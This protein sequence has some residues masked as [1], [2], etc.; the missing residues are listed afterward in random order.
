MPNVDLYINLLTGQAVRNP[1]SAAPMVR[2]DFRNPGS[3]TLNLYFLRRQDTTTENFSYTRFAT[4]TPQAKL[5]RNKAPDY[6]TFVVSFLG[7]NS[8]PIDARLPADSIARILGKMPSIG[9]GNVSVQGNIAQGFQIEFKEAQGGVAQPALTVK[10][11]TPT[12]GEAVVEQLQ[13]GAIGFNSVQKI[14]FREAPLFTA[15]GWVEIGVPVTPGWSATLDTTGMNERF[16]DIGDLILEVTL[17]SQGVRSGADGVTFLEG[18]TRA[19]ADGQA[20]GNAAENNVDFYAFQDADGIA[21]LVAKDGDTVFGPRLWTS[22]DIGKSIDDGGGWIR[23]ET[24]I[25]SVI[26]TPYYNAAKLNYPFADG[27]FLANDIATNIAHIDIG[28]SVTRIY[29]SATAVFTVNDVGHGIIGDKIPAGTFIERFIDIQ[30]VVL[31]AAATGVA[32]GLSWT[33]IAIAGNRFDSASALF[34]GADLGAKIEA[35][36]IPAGTYITSIV[37][38]T[39]I[40]ISQKALAAVSGQAW[41]LRQKTSFIAPAVSSVQTGTLSIPEK[42]R[43][44][45]TRSPIGGSIKLR[46]GAD[47]SMPIVEIAAPINAAAI[48]SALNGI[49]SNYGGV[50]VLETVP[51]GEFEITWGVKGKQHLIVVDETL[52]LYDPKVLQLPLGDQEQEWVILPPEEEELQQQNQQ[53]PTL[54]SVVKLSRFGLHIVGVNNVNYKQLVSQPRVERVYD[55]SFALKIRARYV[56]VMDQTPVAIPGEEWV[57]GNNTFYLDAYEN[58]EDKGGLQFYDWVGYTMPRNNRAIYKGINYNRIERMQQMRPF[59]GVA[60]SFLNGRLIDIQ[61]YSFTTSLYVDVLYTYYQTPLAAQVVAPPPISPAGVVIHFVSVGGFT[62]ITQL[63][64]FGGFNDNTGTFGEFHQS[65]T[66]KRWHAN[67]WEQAIFFN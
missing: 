13:I 17:E 15:T 37:S 30:T 48:E 19:G 46:D 5:R 21:W 40:T 38:T 3:Y 67:I 11:V 56:Q 36:Q 45:L 63:L 59:Y 32:T 64:P 61:L 18:T 22:V 50:S 62:G 12:N 66:R 55:G 16:W 29:K 35:P 7:Y 65:W 47:P 4:G 26:D 1:T 44:T 39:Q 51:N 8:V 49:Y 60:R 6:C 41:T 58:I 28:I 52:A 14:T 2:P 25:E 54:P 33:I 53:Q 31:S 27:V 43:V 23:S 57:R 10:V 24:I 20:L 34:T 9:S 42:Q